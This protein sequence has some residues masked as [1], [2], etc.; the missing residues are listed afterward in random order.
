[1]RYISPG[2]NKKVLYLIIIFLSLILLKGCTLSKEPKS[3]SELDFSS[4]L[5]WPK[6]D[7][8]TITSSNGITFFMVEN[9][10]LPLVK[11]IL[12]IRTG[13]FQVPEGKE[14]LA[15]ILGKVMRSGGTKKYPGKELNR[16]LEDKAA[17]I[18]IS[19]GRVSGDAYLNVLKRDFYDLLPVFVDFLQHP[20]FPQEKIS[21]AKHQLKT[22]IAR[23]NDQQREIAFR[24]FKKLIYG[25]NSVYARVPEYDTVDRI[26][27]EDLTSF[28]KQAFN[29]SNLLVGVVGDFDTQKLKSKLIEEFKS[30][31]E[32]QKSESQFPSV[33]YQPSSSKVYLVD[34]PDVNQSFV[35]M[36]HIGSFRKNPDY[37]ELQV[38]NKVLS[39]GFS[40]RLFEEIRSR[41]GLAYA[42]FGNYG[43][44]YFYPGMF[45]VGLKTKSKSTAKAIME[46][47]KILS[48]L[49]KSGVE[50]EEL[51]QAKD[52]FL[53]SLVFRF[54]SPEKVLERRM[55]YAYRGMD[56]DSFQSLI[57][58]I[59]NVT[60]KD[61]QRVAQE[62]IQIDSLQ[63][64]VV[65]N[66]K[67]LGD[68][69]KK[70]GPVQEIDIN[71]KFN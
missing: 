6:L 35:L 47:K 53:N 45:F 10:E 44:N 32:D 62:Y 36:G 52:Q 27:R 5:K 15:E 20:L 29:G 68:Q 31:P 51:Q 60:A 25:E 65:G 18:E 9:H 22:K 61:V 41:L 48:D 28:H 37:P 54:D 17:N 38:M 63:I 30:F 8:E 42:V 19:L 58:E 1:M 49:R 59:K 50:E 40:G 66:K 13:S 71:N 64:L 4:S 70:L 43:C 11:M 55:Y 67:E 26:T 34:K 14:G 2:I 7:I 69:L 12:K 21:L 57:K 3:Y 56:K 24:E 33:K 46:A 16:L 23:R 39:G